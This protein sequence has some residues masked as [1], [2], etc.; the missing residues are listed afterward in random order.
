LDE[1]LVFSNGRGL[2]ES[3]QIH[4]AS[5]SIF[6]VDSGRFDEGLAEAASIVPILRENG[7]RLFEHDALAGQ[8]VAL[9]ERGEDAADAAERALE[10]ARGT[11]DAAY[12]AFAAWAVAPALITAGRTDE[13]R[14]LLCAVADNPGHDHS[15]YCHHLPRLARAAQALE[16]DDLLARL[17]AGVP[18]TLPRQQ[19]AL[20][21]V[22]AIQAERAGDHAAAAALYADAADRWEQFTE[23]IEQGHALL[24]HGRSL[25]AAA[26]PGADVA[27]R[28]ARALFDQMGARRRIDECDSLIAQA[29]KLSS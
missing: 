3:V 21:T 14:E 17:T 29:S 18:S 5:R 7:N 16:D 26:D 6:L 22:R 23:M 8:A 24:G 28:R 10:I 27:L 11:G 9:D 20:V 12:L 25:A 1:A 4:H 13:A 19:H 2:A 15:E